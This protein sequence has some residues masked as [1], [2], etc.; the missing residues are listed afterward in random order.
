MANSDSAADYKCKLCFLEFDS[1]KSVL[2]HELTHMVGGS[3]NADEVKTGTKRRKN[4]G[5]PKFRKRHRKGPKTL[6][7]SVDPSMAELEDDVR[8]GLLNCPPGSEFRVLSRLFLPDPNF[9]RQVSNR[10][11][12]DLQGVLESDDE[13]GI[14]DIQGFGST[15]TGLA[16]KDSDIDF[17]ISP[18]YR[19]KSFSKQFKRVNDLLHR[20]KLFTNILPIRG[21]RVPIIK[22]RHVQS[23]VN[24]DINMSSSFGV[25]NTQFILKLFKF[26]RRIHPLMVV[27]KI[28]AKSWGITKTTRMTNYCLFLLVVFY[29]Q[30]C[31]NP[32]LPP[33]KRF[34]SGVAPQISEGVNFAFNERLP[35]HTKNG[36][37]I[38]TLVKGF[39]KFYSEFNFAENIICTYLGKSLNRFGFL[40]GS[41]V[42]PEYR[43]Q[44]QFMRQRNEELKAQGGADWARDIRTADIN[45]SGLMV[46]QDMFCFNSNTARSVGPQV[47]ELFKRQIVHGHKICRDSP[48]NLSHL[49]LRLF[50]EA[51]PEIETPLAPT[52]APGAVTISPN[53]PPAASNTPA[54]PSKSKQ[55]ALLTCRLTPVETELFFVRLYLRKI[56]PDKVYEKRDIDRTWCDKVVFSI[57]KVLTDLYAM[58]LKQTGN[59]RQNGRFRINAELEAFADTWQQ[60]KC[61][62]KKGY[63]VFLQEQASFAEMTLQQRKCMEPLVRGM[64]TVGTDTSNFSGVTITMQPVATP[65]KNHLPLFFKDFTSRVRVFLKAYLEK[66]AAEATETTE[67]VKE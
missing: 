32:I 58:N 14:W 59:R 38:L 37:N 15:I 10:I 1:I 48:N 35:N 34:S 28:W 6:L 4:G 46:V 61:D 25:Y 56:N 11:V 54:P 17:Y 5:K 22:C 12:N 39:F 67:P 9:V 40:G 45:C 42:F 16:F 33:M 49:L 21:A 65:Q 36:A 3:K 26:D 24:L 53:N 43:T 66:F 55:T 2:R 52:I 8:D 51:A 63:A 29:L 27:L 30:N 47:F 57:E 18:E 23:G 7:A 50:F 44:I 13:S 60:R 31:P 41:A 64:V 19:F 62:P 20:S